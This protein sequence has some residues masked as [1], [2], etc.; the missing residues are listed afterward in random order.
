M[1]RRLPWRTFFTAFTLTLC[2]L[3]QI[4]AFFFI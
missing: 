3:G 1:F 2:V 4:L